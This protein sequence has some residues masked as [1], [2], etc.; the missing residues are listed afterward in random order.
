MTPGSQ[1]KGEPI[2]DQLIVPVLDGELDRLWSAAGSARLRFMRFSHFGLP[3]RDVRRSLQFYSAHFGFDPATA[4]EYPD[5]TVLVR[6]AD[7]FDLALHPVG[8]IEPSPSFLDAGFKAA[9]P[10]DVRALMDRMDADGITI[11]E[12]MMKPPTRRSSASTPTGT[13]L[14]WTG[15]RLSPIIQTLEQALSDAWIPAIFAAKALGQ[16][17]PRL[18]GRLGGNARVRGPPYPRLQALAA[19]ASLPEYTAE[20]LVCRAL[21]EIANGARNS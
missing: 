6:N 19:A 12:R 10:A 4:Q 18:T 11:V 2:G 3:V 14:R 15:S 20:P 17:M 21:A 1:H 8:H 7:G 13:G 16:L 9:E 5:G